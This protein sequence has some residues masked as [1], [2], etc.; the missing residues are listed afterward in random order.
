MRPEVAP[1]DFHTAATRAFFL[2]VHLD[3]CSGSNE[4]DCVSPETGRRMA[5]QSPMLFTRYDHAEAT[6]SRHL[7]RLKG[8]VTE[9][10]TPT[11]R[12]SLLRPAEAD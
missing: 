8:A 2:F 12:E 6:G 9:H 10:D 3:E 4:D 7:G 1:P 5:E 11:R